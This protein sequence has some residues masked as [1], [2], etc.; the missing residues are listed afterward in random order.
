MRKINNES[1][2]TIV[3]GILYMGDVQGPDNM[4]DTSM[5]TMQVGRWTE[6]SLY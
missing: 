2:K 6:V 4:N 5:K 3:A 1:R